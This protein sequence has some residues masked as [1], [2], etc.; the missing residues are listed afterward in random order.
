MNII[1]VVAERDFNQIVVIT[2]RARQPTNSPR[3][4]PLKIGVH[5]QE[6]LDGIFSLEK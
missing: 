4:K 6:L 3:I 5:D 2:P 1:P